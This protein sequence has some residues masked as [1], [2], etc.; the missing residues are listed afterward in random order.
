MYPY[1][2]VDLPP[3][4]DPTERSWYM[5]A[6]N[7][8][9]IVWT[10]PYVD[11]GSGKLV[12]S[13]ATPVYNPYE[14]QPIGVVGIDVSLESLTRLLS[15][16][17]V[18]QDGH[19]VL[20]DGSGQ[21]LAHP[22]PSQIG[23]EFTNSEL[24]KSALNKNYG[25]VDYIE[26]GDAKFAVFSTLPRT[27]WKIMSLISYKEIN[28]HVQAQLK[29]TFFV[30]LVF[31]FLAL[32]TGIL[33]TNKLLIRPVSR[34]V[35]G[36][37]A[38]AKG[39]F[40]TEISVASNDELGWLAQSFVSLQQDL[41][42]LIG[43]VSQASDTVSG[44]SQ[45]VSAS[46]QEISASI[47]QAAATSNEFASSVEQTSGHIQSIDSDGTEIRDIANS[48]E[49]LIFQAVD[50]MENIEHSFGELHQS[51]EKLSLQSTEIGKI[52][53]VI[54]GISDQ[55][56]LLALNAA[57]EAARAG[58]QGRGFAVVADEV[59]LLAEQSAKATEQI[60][61]LLRETDIQINQAMAEANKS[62]TEVKSG[63]SVVKNA[64]DTFERIGAAINNISTRIQEIAASSLQLSSGSEELAATTEEQSATLQQ[65]TATTEELSEQA[66]LLMELISGFQI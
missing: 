8:K 23:Q 61:E 43:Q 13:I 58:E 16:R 27:G 4:F 34:L 49:K 30:G 40:R 54:R 10:E 28:D 62:I 24:L 47:E 2:K 1:P 59:R 18:G 31:L 32:A 66:Q 14:T 57:I 50:Q 35:Q 11:T 19:I 45:S 15:T 26:Q 53:D 42:R 33:F 17:K 25:D 20:L 44:I 38:I 55:T 12:V 46:V 41:G 60:A 3:G 21:L 36:A 51:V 39:N 7:S 29:R 65:I 56:N 5:Q 64:G 52:T 37:G 48:G 22:D 6:V 9:G 63:S